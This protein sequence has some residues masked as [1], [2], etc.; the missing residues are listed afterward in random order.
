MLLFSDIASG[1]VENVDMIWVVVN[2]I[3]RNHSL[4][5]I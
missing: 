3:E 4:G 2:L 1:S 5:D